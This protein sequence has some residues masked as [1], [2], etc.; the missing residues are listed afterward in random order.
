MIVRQANRVQITGP[1]T[2][3]NVVTLI[4]EPDVFAGDG[5]IVDLSGITVADSSALSLMLE[6]VRRYGG[7][8]KHI[9][10]ANLSPGLRSLAELYGVLDLIPVA[11][12]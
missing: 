11:N 8:D 5:V 10:F 3:D 6:W 9:A 4:A 12:A 1:V 7:P 2:L